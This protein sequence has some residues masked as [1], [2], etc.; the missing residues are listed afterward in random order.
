MQRWAIASVLLCNACLCAAPA[1]G[2]RPPQSAPAPAPD[3]AAALLDSLAAAAAS[4]S[5]PAVRTP[6][7]EDTCAGFDEST[8]G[9]LLMNCQIQTALGVQG[10][11]WTTHLLARPTLHLGGPTFTS[12]LQAL[13]LGSADDAPY[14]SIANATIQIAGPDGLL[15]PVG[16]LLGDVANHVASGVDAL[17]LPEK[18]LTAVYTPA[19]TNLSGVDFSLFFART[20]AK[21]SFSGIRLTKGT[22]YVSG[23]SARQ[24]HLYFNCG[25][26]FAPFL[27]DF[28]G[29]TLVFLNNTLGQMSFS[30]CTAVTVQRAT[31]YYLTPPFTQATLIDISPDQLTWT[32]Q[33]HDGYPADDF[34]LRLRQ[35]VYIAFDP[36]TRLI[37]ANTSDIYPLI[38]SVQKVPPPPSGR[39]LAQASPAAFQFTLQYIVPNV[40]VGDLLAERGNDQSGMALAV[41][42]SKNMT[43]RNMRVHMSGVFCFFDSE[44]TNTT[45]DS[46]VAQPFPGKIG[47]GSQPAL[48]T[49][50][51]DG[52]HSANSRIGPQ[53]LNN[54]LDGNGDDGIAVHGTYLLVVAFDPSQKAV[55]VALGN[56]MQMQPYD[57]LAAYLPSTQ[58]LGEA[59]VESVTR[60]EAPAGAPAASTTL[61]RLDFAKATFYYVTVQE[62]PPQWA[63]LLTFDCFIAPRNKVGSGYVISGNTVT[64]NRGR[65]MILKGSSGLVLNNQITINR[66]TGIMVQPE[67]YP[68]VEA[69]FAH[70]VTIRGNS[71]TAPFGGIQVIY[72]RGGDYTPGIWPNHQG[73]LITNNT[74]S[75]AAYAPLLITSAQGVT[76]SDNRIVNALCYKS[77]VGSALSFVPRGALIFVENS[78]GVAFSGNTFE[79]AAPGC[80]VYGDY[81]APVK[82]GV[83]VTEVTGLS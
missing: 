13:P 29:S 61:P 82:L 71:V 66:F 14:R 72:V 25:P 34:L 65:G 32:I 73:I 44:N 47:D 68:F 12:F 45:F 76:I 10:M 62:V 3:P 28:S 83:N 24:Q 19:G 7:E 18:H 51:A 11:P 37:K 53:V 55:T 31:M 69:D 78:V 8:Q 6:R 50:N 1:A 17:G 57:T 27:V 38:G 30:N 2:A 67:T 52:L 33:V 75:D 16:G 26:R 81:A 79:A 43:V 63:N 9:A 15:P 59:I 70:Q 22:Y 46:N 56:P 64:N 74:I 48:L 40:F 41:S 23:F 42:S 54:V 4:A 49:S 77:V 39:R 60:I 80:F 21:R 35:Q 36:V 20:I 5:L 58:P